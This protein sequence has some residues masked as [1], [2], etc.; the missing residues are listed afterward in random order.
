MLVPDGLRECSLVNLWVLMTPQSL[1]EY[2][3]QVRY[4]ILFVYITGS[5]KCTRSSATKVALVVV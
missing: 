4:I 5:N 3:T 1:W 2:I